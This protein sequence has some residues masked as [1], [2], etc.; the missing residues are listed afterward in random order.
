MS[1][2]HVNPIQ[3]VQAVTQSYDS[4]ESHSGGVSEELLAIAGRLREA[5]EGLS[6]WVQ[7]HALMRSEDEGARESAAKDLNHLNGVFQNTHE[8][9]LSY[10]QQ[11]PEL[12]DTP[13]AYQ[14]LQTI[15]KCFLE[16]AAK[17][18]PSELPLYG[19]TSWGELILSTKE[20]KW[21]ADMLF[22]FFEQVPAANWKSV[23]QILA[24]TKEN[25][26]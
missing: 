16:D 18:T 3:L 1:T 8:E 12:S 24:Y 4:K 22:P 11:I 25:L 9:L 23:R 17:E 26:L 20:V 19:F 14:M 7:I 13:A 15:E 10:A 2:M 6:A 5:L 21:T